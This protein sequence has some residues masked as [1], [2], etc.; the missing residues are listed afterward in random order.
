MPKAPRSHG[1]SFVF[2]VEV[3]LEKRLQQLINALV[4]RHARATRSSTRRAHFCCRPRKEYDI[5]LQMT[6]SFSILSTPISH[7]AHDAHRHNKGEDGVVV[8]TQPAVLRSA[9]RVDAGQP[10]SYADDH[11]R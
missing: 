5:K 1:L 3:V 9:V 11:R 4:A 8:S 2:E 7:R 10:Y 6:R